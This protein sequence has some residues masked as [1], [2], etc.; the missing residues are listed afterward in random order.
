MDTLQKDRGARFEEIAAQYTARA[1]SLSALIP[2]AEQRDPN[3]NASWAI[4]EAELA[5]CVEQAT[6]WTTMAATARTVQASEAAPAP[7]TT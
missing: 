4:H 6:H 5:R 3:S 7:A 1:A 2:P